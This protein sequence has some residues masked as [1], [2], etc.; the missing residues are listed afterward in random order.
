M[1]AAV[2]A[3]RSAFVLALDDRIRDLRKSSPGLRFT[4]IDRAPWFKFNFAWNILGKGES[5]RDLVLVRVERDP[6]S[7]AGEVGNPPPR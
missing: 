7:G 3:G 1:A 4:E 2:P 6:S 5:S